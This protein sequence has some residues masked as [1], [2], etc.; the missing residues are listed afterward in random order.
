MFTWSADLSALTMIIVIAVRSLE[1]VAL[2]VAVWMIWKGLRAAVKAMAG[3]PRL[4][5]ETTHGRAR[6]AKLTEAKD[7]ARGKGAKPPWADH[8]YTD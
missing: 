4:M 3:S 5:G 6:A 7:A 2:V 8:G 1:V